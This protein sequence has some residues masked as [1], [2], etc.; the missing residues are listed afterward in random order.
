M[1]QMKAASLFAD[2]TR[3]FFVAN[4]ESETEAKIL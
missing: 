1:P 2:K 3:S 4:S